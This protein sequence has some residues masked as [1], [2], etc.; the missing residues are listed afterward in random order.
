MLTLVDAN[1]A[2][3]SP[4]H[5]LWHLTFSH[6][7]EKAR[8]ALDHK[9]LAHVRRR[10]IPGRHRDL[11]RSLSGGSTLPVLVVDGEA[12]GD[13]T[14]I[15]AYLEG[16]YPDPPL[17]PAEPEVCRR[18]LALE[19]F[20][21]EQLGPYIRR[22]VIHHMLPERKLTADFFVPDM[23]RGRRLLSPMLYPAIKR[24]IKS[25]LDITD[26]TVEQA[27][28]KLHAAGERFRAELQPNGYLAGDGFSVADLTLAAMVSVAVTPDQFPYPQ[29]QRD[30]PR[31]APVRDVLAE[32]GLP[33]WARDIYKRHRPPDR[34]QPTADARS[35]SRVS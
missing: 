29:P 6:Y 11:A 20:F 26:A 22:L 35:L 9:G 30:H 7:N 4:T 1:D 16:R 23:S 17:Y 25:D 18:A 19:E 13:S 15:I 3:Q 10:V 5:V 2:S 8:W 14:E 28:E 31:L 21:D 34:S 33:D 32:S 27:F 24:R 12:I